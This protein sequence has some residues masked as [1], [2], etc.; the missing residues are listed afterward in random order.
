M[1]PLSFFAFPIL[2]LIQLLGPLVFIVHPVVVLSELRFCLRI[3]TSFLFA[4]FL[5]NSFFRFLCPLYARVLPALLNAA[6]SVS[7]SQM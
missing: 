4:V 5:D 2:F 1:H 7:V 3:R 6:S